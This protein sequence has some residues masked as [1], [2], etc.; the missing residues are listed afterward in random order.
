LLQE[1][2]YDDYAELAKYIGKEL[3]DEK[4]QTMDEQILSNPTRLIDVL[5]KELIVGTTDQ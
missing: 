2:C 1:Y 4:S 5:V 3:I